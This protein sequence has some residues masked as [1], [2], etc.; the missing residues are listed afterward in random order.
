[1]GIARNL[2]RLVPNGSGLLPNANIEAV[3][4]SK[5]T[6]QVADANAPSGS[7]VQMLQWGYNSVY[8]NF[9]QN[10]EFALPSPLGDGSIVITP[11]NANNKI[12]VQAQINCGQ[13][14]TWRVNYFKFY[15]SIGGGGSNHFASTG[16]IA[17]IANHNGGMQTIPFDYLLSLNTT[18]QVAIR[19]NQI[20]HA[21]G[22]Y[23][24]LN[25]NNL[26]NDQSPNN[27]INAYTTVTLTEIT[28]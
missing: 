11:S 5:L 15:F 27:T 23:L 24:H 28:A 22:G 4:A 1:M 8:E 16:S 19:V 7:V 14:D 10:S 25:Q 20:G 9:G 13:E 26:T 12:R 21:S 6:G 3:A 2:A 18:A 17:Y